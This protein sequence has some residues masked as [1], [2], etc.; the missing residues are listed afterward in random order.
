VKRVISAAKA[1]AL[2][3][4]REILHVLPQEYIVD[5]QDGI[6][7]PVGMA[8]VRL[9]SEVH[10]VTAAA[11]SAQNIV[12]CIIEAGYDVADIVL[13]PYA[14]S[15]AVLEPDERDLGVCIIDIGGGTT[16]IAMFFDGSIRYTSVIG[17]G[18][19]HVTSDLSQGLRTSMDQ[20]E[21]I[22]KKYGVALQTLLENDELIKVPG[23]GGR[24]SREISRSVLS[25]I[26]QPRMEEMFSL[27]LREMEKSNVFD[28]MG[29]GVVLTGGASLLEGTL[30]LAE[31]VM[32]MP[33]KIGEPIVS[34]G[35]VE[36]VKSPIFATGVGL[37]YYAFDYGENRSPDDRAGF[38]WIVNRLKEIFEN[39]F[40]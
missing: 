15:I 20:A 10:I 6:K 17:L 24:A 33:V 2:P 14:S 9:E 34:G 40:K 11:A 39:L 13:E 22:K 7:Y 28:S 25:A 30:E 3:M 23:V 32:G 36:T 1:I 37:V 21:E 35:L 19:Q 26:I 29:A 27:A 31:R 16:D 38:G 12:N 5:D 4:D 8:G 18:G